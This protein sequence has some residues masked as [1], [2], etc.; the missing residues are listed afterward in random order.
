[1]QKSTFSKII[2]SAVIAVAASVQA[3]SAVSNEGD[4]RTSGTHS[5]SADDHTPFVAVVL[6]GFDNWD[7]NSDGTLEPDEINRAVANPQIK[8]D[9]AAAVGAIKLIGRRKG[10]PLPAL[11]KAFFLEYDET[12]RAEAARLTAKS[13]ETSTIDSVGV[14]SN[15]SASPQLGQSAI[16]D[17]YFLASKARIA[18]GE[19][20]PF[21]GEFKLQDM[22]QGAL[23]DC[24]FVSSIGTMVVHRPDYL[25]ELMVQQADGSFKVTFPGTKPILVEKPTDGEM[26]LS[27]TT[28]GDGAWLVVMEQ[29][30]GRYRSMRK[31]GTAD[32]DGTEI[33]RK[34]GDS[35]DTIELLTGHAF[36]RIRF[37]KTMAQRE[38]KADEILPEVRHTL[39]AAIN[40]HR[41]I[42]AGIL[43]TYTSRGSN[44]TSSGD[45]SNSS[46]TT[47]PVGSNLDGGDANHGD[48]NHVDDSHVDDSALPKVPPNFSVNHVYA[49]VGYDADSDV[50]TIWNPHGQHFDPKGP[51]GQTN[52]YPTDHGLFKLP[53][54]EAYRFYT[55][56]TFE[57]ENPAPQHGGHSPSIAEP[58]K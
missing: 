16:W 43:S 25:R 6:R 33:L 24:F 20:A 31:G 38:Q 54:K 19:A 45:G 29:A 34:G 30:F 58:T 13:V 9:D 32:V 14:D 22:K 41:L 10:P 57:T 39:V 52:G 36:H 44:G 26:T 35:G 4:Q 2:A 48:A 28:A 8:G 18:A 56:F 50:I 7:S 51:P 3:G 27:S 17:Q 21:T 46:A 23:G 47:N 42:T 11:T 53:L 1:M 5:T 15:N 49:I 40:D 12:A 37:P 55:S